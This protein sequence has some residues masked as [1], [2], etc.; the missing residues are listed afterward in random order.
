LGNN[1]SKFGWNLLTPYQRSFKDK[2]LVFWR[3]FTSCEP[4]CLFLEL[5]NQAI[6]HERNKTFYLQQNNIGKVGRLS[7][8]NRL[9]NILSLI[10]DKW[11]DQSLTTVKKM[12]NDIIIENIPAKYS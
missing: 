4:E 6:H 1:G 2:A 12:L 5:L 10:G 11:M 8:E 9:N 3:I 7:L